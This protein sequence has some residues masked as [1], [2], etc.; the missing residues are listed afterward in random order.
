MSTVNSSINNQKPPLDGVRVID[1]ATVVA[2]PGTARYLGDFGADVIK[3]ER[4]GGD[5]TRTMGWKSQED[6]DSLW[7]KILNRN[8][9]SIVLDLKKKSDLEVALRLVKNADVFIENMRPGALE[10]LGMGPELLLKE[11]P[12]LIILRVTGFG[13]S[14]PYAGRA[15][16]ATIA[17]S[18][19]GLADITG[20][21]N[22]GPLLPPI[23]LT[24]EV[25]ALAGAFAVMVALRHAELTKVGQVID[26]NL[27]ESMLQIMGP[28]PAAWDRLGYL[29]PRL[30][31]GI[32]YTV[33]RGTYQCS[34]GVWVAVSASAESVAQR[35]LALFELEGDKRFSDFQ[36]RFENRSA[37]ELVTKDWIKSRTSEK[38]IAEFNAI[39][40]AIAP[41]YNMKNVVEDAHIIER[42]ALVRVDNVLMQNVIARLSR[43][44]G[45]IRKAGPSLNADEKEI[46]NELG[47]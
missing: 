24:D 13:Q 36:A 26:V 3:I 32:P 29:Q 18:L 12:K 2:A 15:G 40:A 46:R 35:L 21:P 38:V 30:G 33:P 1:M 28:L 25:T 11:N 41:V 39:D 45:H 6:A 14:G 43:T 5:A 8:K 9:R 44:P 31:S 16:F 22:G 37:L 27:L 17:E 19:S 42:K 7:W 10:R 23:A 20:E 47:I 34:D 4:P